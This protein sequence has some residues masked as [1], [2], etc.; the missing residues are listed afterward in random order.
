VTIG[1]DRPLVQPFDYA[2]PE[3]TD[4]DLTVTLTDA[5]GATVLDYRGKITLR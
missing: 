4:G 3:I 5:S 1:P 2:G